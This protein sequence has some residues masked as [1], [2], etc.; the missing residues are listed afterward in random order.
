MRGEKRERGGKKKRKK[1][2]EIEIPFYNAV[3]IYYQCIYA[4]LWG[5]HILVDPGALLA[6]LYYFFGPFRLS[7]APTICLWVSEDGEFT[8]F[9][10]D[11]KADA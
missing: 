3:S 7:L 6:V 10:E 11:N 2:T 9:L 4:I 1:K 5:I 8:I